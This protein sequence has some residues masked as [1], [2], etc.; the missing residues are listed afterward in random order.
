[1]RTSGSWAR[2][3]IRTSALATAVLAAAVAPRAQ[4]TDLA[5]LLGRVGERVAEYYKRAQNIICTEKV[6]AQQIDSSWSTDG[7]P[8]TLEYELHLEAEGLDGDG[9]V[10]DVKIA[11]ELRKV[12]GRA[13]RPT[14]LEGCFD[15][16]TTEPEPLAFLLPANQHEYT[17]TSAEFGKGKD[18]N[19]LVLEYVHNQT[20][21]PEIKEDKRKRPECFQISLPVTTKG[22]VWIDPATY[23]VLRVEEQLAHRVDVRVPYAQQRKMNLPD[24]LTIERFQTTTKYAVV[25]F[26]NPDEVL[27]LPSS[28]EELAMM[29]GAGSHRKR[30]EFSAYHRFL[31]G[32]RIVK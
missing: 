31:T 18:R 5:F 12:N 17:F 32:G 14:E 9:A 11:R 19:T 1:M 16:D 13:P 20:G 24:F 25:K 7:F 4:T 15:P 28:I 30:Q 6:T 26:T 23:D 21:R 10:H 2:N 3:T 8:R 27:L 29:R 22:R